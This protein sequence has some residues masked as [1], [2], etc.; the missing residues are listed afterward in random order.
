M[1]H[2]RLSPVPGFAELRA[3]GDGLWLVGGAVR[4]ALLNQ[5]VRDLDVVVEGDALVLARQLGEVVSIHERFGTAEVRLPAS[6]VKVNLASARTETYPRPGALPDVTLGASIADDLR[7]RDFSVNAIAVSLDD[8]HELDVA[9]ARDDL[10]AGVLRV[11]HDASFVDD[12]TRLLRMVRYAQRLTLTPEPHTAALAHAAAHDGAL[13]EVTRDR[14]ANELRLALL[15][16]DPLLTLDALHDATAAATPR[17]DVEL[18]RAALALLPDGRLDLI[19]VVSGAIGEPRAAGRNIQWFD[20]SRPGRRRAV[21]TAGADVLA[22]ELALAPRPSEVFALARHL[23]P[24]MVAL[25]GALGAEAQ[26]RAY[27]DELRHITLNINGRDLIAAGFPEGP[28]IRGALDRALAARLD[29]EIP[30]DR[31]AELR[32]ALDR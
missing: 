21:E 16:P 2:D 18:A 25:A 6:G 17:V 28:A 29:G 12:P 19:A 8:G 20:D 5:P 3:R 23:P 15:E 7:R 11:L 9:G 1:L 10:A 26:A 30:A 24:E 27:L 22:S 4:D 31:E 32:I 13:L 14:I